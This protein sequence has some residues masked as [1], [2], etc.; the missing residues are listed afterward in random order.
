MTEFR[1]Q[2]A[3]Y[4]LLAKVRD[5][6]LFV[7]SVRYEVDKSLTENDELENN[8]WVQKGITTPKIQL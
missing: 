3:F 7:L 5:L 6:S 2:T 4:G 8:S 1:D